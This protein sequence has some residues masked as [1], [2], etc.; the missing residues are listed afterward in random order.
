MRQMR[1]ILLLAA[2]GFIFTAVYIGML[3]LDL[4]AETERAND[5]EHKYSVVQLEVDGL[6]LLQEAQATS[7]QDLQH[8]AAECEIDRDIARQKL[9]D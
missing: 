2:T 3:A 9:D 5:L 7:Y 1:K 4:K 8:I 6:R